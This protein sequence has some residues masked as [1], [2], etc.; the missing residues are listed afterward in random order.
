MTIWLDITDLTAWKGH[1]TGIQRVVFNIASRIQRDNENVK[2]FY[3]DPHNRM[4]YEKT[5]DLQEWLTINNEL[6]QVPKVALK[7]RAVNLIPHKIKIITPKPVKV[8][9]IKAVKYAL[10]KKRIINQHKNSKHNSDLEAKFSSEDTVI[11]LGNCWDNQNI[12]LDLGLLK[13]RLN[14]KL[15][16][17]VYDLI[18]VF[19]PQFFGGMLA[20]KYTNYLFEAVT[21]CDLLLPISKST[22][23]DIMRFCDLIEAPKPITKVIRLGDE[24]SSSEQPKKPEW[25]RDKNFILCVGTI[26]IRKN[27]MLLYYAYKKLITE[28][29]NVP[30][31][32]IAGSKGWFTDDVITLFKHDLSL[33]DQVIIVNNS[34]DEELAWLYDNCLFTIYPSFY[35]G[36]GLPVTESLARGKIVLC[37]NSSSIPEAGGILAEYF[38]PYDAN[39]LS[40]LILKYKDDNAIR[41]SKEIEIKK[42][43]K[44]TTWENCYISLSELLK[45]KTKIN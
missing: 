42:M 13:R 39:V 14:F 10:D 3:Y 8:A 21:N 36:W 1:L 2:F 11:V 15:I 17:V 38:S 44:I 22:E 43:Y 40:E 32:I 30:K 28:G 9:A 6:S 31:L 26:E 35:E 4:F 16:N 37:S 29:Y 24:I 12:I 19:E 23:K 45:T 27:H 33:K 20:V 18:A 7:S 5:F 41:K 25:L 34:T